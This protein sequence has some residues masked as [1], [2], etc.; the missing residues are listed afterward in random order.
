MNSATMSAWDFSYNDAT[1]VSFQCAAR[2]RGV[3]LAANPACTTIGTG[4]LSTFD[5]SVRSS[6]AGRTRIALRAR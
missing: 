2:A 1:F 3:A 4:V 6:K 5:A